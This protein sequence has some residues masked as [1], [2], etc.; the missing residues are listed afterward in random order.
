MRGG[1][2]GP[3]STRMSK[4]PSAW[5]VQLTRL[6]VMVWFWPSNT[7]VVTMLGPGAQP[8]KRPISRAAPKDATAPLGRRTASARLLAVRIGIHV[9]EDLVGRSDQTGVKCAHRN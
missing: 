3:P 9:M 4:R 1:W 2:G 8:T 5:L 7:K 6:V